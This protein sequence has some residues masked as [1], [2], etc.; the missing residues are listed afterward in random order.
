MMDRV[1]EVKSSSPK[2]QPLV[3]V[4]ILRATF[5]EPAVLEHLYQLIHHAHLNLSEG[6]FCVQ[7]IQG[8]PVVSDLAKSPRMRGRTE[9]CKLISDIL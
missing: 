6:I 5:T 3:N 4:S 1:T 7:N 2:E 9:T 8:Q